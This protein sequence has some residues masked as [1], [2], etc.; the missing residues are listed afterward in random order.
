MALPPPSNEIVEYV[1]ASAGVSEIRIQE[2]VKKL[3]DWLKLQPHLP[4][5]YGK[6][7]RQ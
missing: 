6:S 3:K 2:A 1:R 7:C 5:D 4:H